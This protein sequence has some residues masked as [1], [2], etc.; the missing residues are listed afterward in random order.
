MV[1]VF[2]KRQGAG[3][4]V[5][6]SFPLRPHVPFLPEKMRRASLK[7]LYTSPADSPATGTLS[8]YKATWKGGFKLPWREAG[9]PKN[10]GGSGPVGCQ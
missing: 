10:I 5:L 8:R 7:M 4:K 6:R 1:L 9:T 2:N 3:P